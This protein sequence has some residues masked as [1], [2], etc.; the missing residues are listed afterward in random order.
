KEYNLPPVILPFIQQHHGTT[1]IEYFF[2]KARKL[3]DETDPRGPEVPESQFRYNGPKPK[4]K[5]IA[6]LMMADAVESATRAEG[7][8]SPGRIEEIVHGLAMSRLLDHQFDESD[9][10]MRDLELIERA[11]IKPL[12]GIYHGRI[13]YPSQKKPHQA[14][15][16]APPTG[17]A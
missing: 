16:A 11:L 8:P 3:H 15:P 13:S 5:E 12:T 2:D 1:L 7:E 17:G 6:I 9:L 14:P 4:S 10:T